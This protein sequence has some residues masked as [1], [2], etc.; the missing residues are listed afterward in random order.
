MKLACA[1]DLVEARKF[2]LDSALLSEPKVNLG[3]ICA[4]MRLD[5]VHEK[6]ACDLIAWRP[7]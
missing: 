7:P 3:K 1:L 4:A 2:A 6:G 5:A